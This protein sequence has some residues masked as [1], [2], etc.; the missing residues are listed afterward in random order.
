MNSN[1]ASNLTRECH[2]LL[3]N[4]E[5]SK[6][7]FPLKTVEEL[8]CLQCMLFSNEKELKEL[9]GGSTYE[10]MVKKMFIYI[11]T[12]EVASLYSWVG[13]KGERKLHRLEIMILMFK[14]VRK[15]FLNLTEKDFETKCK[16]WFRHAKHRFEKRRQSNSTQVR[17][18]VKYIC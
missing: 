15:T 8:K 2:N 13:R 3:A 1:N 18:Y 16:D 12:N 7:S 9:I 6:L 10:E 4:D 17:I 11:F 14:V 5:L